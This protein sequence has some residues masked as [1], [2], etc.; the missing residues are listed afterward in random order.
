MTKE[1]PSV[2]LEQIHLR[3]IG[4]GF[5]RVDQIFAAYEE[6]KK[7]NSQLHFFVLPKTHYIEGLGTD[8]TIRGFLDDDLLAVLKPGHQDQLELLISFGE[9]KDEFKMTDKHGEQFLIPFIK[10]IAFGFKTETKINKLCT[11]Y[12]DFDPDSERPQL[13]IKDVK[14]LRNRLANR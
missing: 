9:K 5:D 12:V 14:D 4:P 11:N 10:K 8:K 13:K 7:D 6:Y 2:G 3:E 1:K